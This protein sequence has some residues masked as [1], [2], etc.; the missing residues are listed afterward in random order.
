MSGVFVES[1]WTQSNW[2]RGSNAGKPR[3]IHAGIIECLYEALDYV[4][5]GKVKV[6]T[7]TY[8]LDEIN[9]T[10]ERVENGEVRFRA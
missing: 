8:S 6:I 10:Y 5:K 4:T 7:E 3:R 1:V 9:R 2:H